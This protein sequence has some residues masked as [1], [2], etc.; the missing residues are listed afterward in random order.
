MKRRSFIRSGAIGAAVLGLGNPAMVKP[1]EWWE[2]LT[3]KGIF[4]I[5]KSTEFCEIEEVVDDSLGIRMPL[6]SITHS[7]GGVIWLP[8]RTVSTGHKIGVMESLAHLV[9]FDLNRYLFNLR[10][11]ICDKRY[12]NPRP[13][14]IVGPY[15][16]DEKTVKV[17]YAVYWE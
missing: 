6:F 8:I 13:T 7:K 16:E 10:Q 15:I 3:T 12:M 17:T 2:Y 4:E 14:L 9:D 1:K 5:V 11:I